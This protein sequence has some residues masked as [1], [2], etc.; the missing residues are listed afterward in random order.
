MHRDRYRDEASTEKQ[1]ELREIGPHHGAQTAQISV[2]GRERPEGHDQNGEP[3]R[4]AV[5]D[6]RTISGKM[7]SSAK[8]A[9]NS[10]V[11]R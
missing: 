11:P 1:D 10:A 3:H 4:L 5:A 9:Q 2:K 6:P 8:A 7:P